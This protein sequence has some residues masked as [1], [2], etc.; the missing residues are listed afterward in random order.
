MPRSQFGLVFLS[1]FDKKP[2]NLEY[3]PCSFSVVFSAPKSWTPANLRVDLD[4]SNSIAEYAPLNTI[5]GGFVQQMNGNQPGDGQKAVAVMIDV[6]K[7]EGIAEGKE[8]P[9][10]LP[11][12]SDILEKLK[13]K[14]TRALEVCR[15]WEG[16]I[17]S[18]DIE[19]DEKGDARSLV[20][21]A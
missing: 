2:S 8:I 10:R 5:V 12:G 17:A 15:E 13:N 1:A 21:P 7:G 6:V 20:N 4:P 19:G 3:S 11:L 16:L 9:E 14:Y 18:T